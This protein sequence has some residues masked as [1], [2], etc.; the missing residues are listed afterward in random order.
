MTDVS[1]ILS[2]LA[3]HVAAS[4]ARLPLG[5]FANVIGDVAITTDGIGQKALLARKM[6]Q[7][8]TVGIDCV[9]MLVN[10]LLC[11]GALPTAMVDYIA[12]Q[13][14]D[15][16]LLAQLV[17]GLLR[18][19]D[20]ADI[21]IVGGETALL[22][23]II[24]G[25]DLSGT[26]I[27]TLLTDNPI[28]GSFVAPGDVILALPSSGMHSNGFTAALELLLPHYSLLST[29]APLAHSLGETLL[30]PT[31]IYVDVI[32]H[33]LRKIPVTALVNVTGG[34]VQNLTRVAAPN[35]GF[36]L[37]YWPGP[38]PD[39]FNLIAQHTEPKDYRA[40][41]DVYNMGAGFF[42]ITR[43]EHA[44]AATSA[45]KHCGYWLPQVGTVTHDPERRVLIDR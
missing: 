7:Y 20:L 17:K 4:P 38:R 39:I 32:L 18:G 1:Q 23:G 8:D 28:D 43:P 21:T 35:V 22:P 2:L 44:A 26:A 6:R 40:L 29:P 11:V 45:A 16:T 5:Y 34:G 31:L 27:G 42:I 14:H 24:H 33:L 30:T 41:F 12:L 15:P 37:D 3:P 19:A 36:H 9:A 25:F 10:D 13:R